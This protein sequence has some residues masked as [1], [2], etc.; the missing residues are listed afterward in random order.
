MASDTTGHASGSY[1]HAAGPIA[2]LQGGWVLFSGLMLLFSGF[3][4]VFE[5]I[6]A[7]V[8]STWYIGSP[9]YGSLWVW[10]LLWLVFGILMMAA[11]GAV[12]IGRSWGR[13]FGIVVVLLAALVHM[14]SFAA[15]P[16]WSAVMIAIDVLV[17][18]GLTARWNVSEGTAASDQP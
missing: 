12:T 3:W 9:V 10:A 13:W 5:G 16:W 1:D 4:V 11:G 2:M 18:F 15:Y 14:A 6:F 17:L 8:R 7:F